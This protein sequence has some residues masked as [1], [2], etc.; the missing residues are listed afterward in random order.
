MI[1]PQL[2]SE[3]IN[4]RYLL[5]H[6]NLTIDEAKLVREIS[7]LNDRLDSIRYQHNASRE[8]RKLQQE[9]DHREDQLVVL[10]ST[11]DTFSISFR[12]A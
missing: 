12:C 11:I 10:R 1:N 4:T 9:I 3:P 2:L 8:A 6:L 7:D 5:S